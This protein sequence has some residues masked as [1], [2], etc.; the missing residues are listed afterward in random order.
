MILGLIRP[1]NVPG[2]SFFEPW[3]RSL[4]ILSSDSVKI[5]EL[6]GIL[7]NIGFTIPNFFANLEG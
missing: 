4:N 5:L 3:I 2:G 7:E 1:A 6:L